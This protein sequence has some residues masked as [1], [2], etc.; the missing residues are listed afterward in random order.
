MKLLLTTVGIRGGALDVGDRE[1]LE[2]LNSI[3]KESHFVELELDPNTDWYSKLFQRECRRLDKR[4]ANFSMSCQCHEK[5][6]SHGNSNFL[7]RFLIVLATGLRFTR[8][9]SQE[10]SNGQGSWNVQ[11]N[12][13]RLVMTHLALLQGTWI[14]SMSELIREFNRALCSPMLW[15][16]V[17]SSHEAMSLLRL[18]YVA[19]W[20]SI[21]AHKQPPRSLEEFTTSTFWSIP[22]RYSGVVVQWYHD[23]Y[24]E[25]WTRLVNLS[26][27]IVLII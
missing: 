27:L 23:G 14:V 26:T 9:R 19:I 7:T 13:R 6:R 1:R 25:K 24:Q 20:Y 2:R 18:M 21:Q 16:A 17:S 10:D 3:S 4:R 15:K 8:A 11:T 5:L 12:F 22:S